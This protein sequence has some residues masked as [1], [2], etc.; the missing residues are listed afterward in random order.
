[1]LIY[2]HDKELNIFHDLRISNYEFYLEEGEY[3]KRFEIVLKNNKPVDSNDDSEDSN[4]ETEDDNDITDDISDEFGSLDI[5]FSNRLESIIVIN[6]ALKNIQSVELFNI[7]GQTVYSI[8]NIPSVNYSEFK[9][10]NISSGTY[11]LK[12]NT[13][14]GTL[15][16]KVLVE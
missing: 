8:K 1:M 7:L 15:T 14:T 12:L 2:A 11:I 3:L 5:H 4:D 6:P 10:K 13:E 9:A 16:K